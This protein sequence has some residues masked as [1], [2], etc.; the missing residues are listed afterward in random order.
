MRWNLRSDIIFRALLTI[1]IPRRAG[2]LV[3]VEVEVEVE[4]VDEV[5]PAAAIDIAHDDREVVLVPANRVRAR[6]ARRGR[7]LATASAAGR[8]V[9]RA[10][11]SA[12]PPRVAA[13]ALAPSRLCGRPARLRRSQSHQLPSCPTAT[14]TRRTR[15]ARRATTRP[16]VMMRMRRNDAV[17]NT[18]SHQFMSF[19]R[20]CALS[21]H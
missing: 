11:A 8:R 21:V 14:A 12:H 5:V 7:L 13:R 18:Y 2:G 4:V 10:T 19:T 3:E 6:G 17:R 15:A 16:A 20:T 1:L 9:G